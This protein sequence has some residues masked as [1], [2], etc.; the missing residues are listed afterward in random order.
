MKQLNAWRWKPACIDLEWLIKESVYR[1]V[2]VKLDPLVDRAVGRLKNYY[3][4]RI[5]AKT[6]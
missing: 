6:P 4:N 2:R 3:P 1:H 5:A